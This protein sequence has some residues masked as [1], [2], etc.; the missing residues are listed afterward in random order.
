M[1]DFNYGAKD[2]LRLRYAERRERIPQVEDA[3]KR[4]GLVLLLQKAR[5]SKHDSTPTRDHHQERR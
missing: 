2:Y 1:P 5:P 4:M 3:V